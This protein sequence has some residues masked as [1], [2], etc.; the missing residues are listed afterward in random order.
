[1]TRALVIRVGL[2]NCNQ[3]F[4][5]HNPPRRHLVLL[6]DRAGISPALLLLAQLRWHQAIRFHLQ[7]VGARQVLHLHYY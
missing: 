3:M 4:V 1:M 6:L 2:R 7:R 5:V